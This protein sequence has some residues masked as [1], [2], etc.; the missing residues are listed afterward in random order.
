MA[1]KGAPDIDIFS[2]LSI[3]SKGN[4]LSIKGKLTGDNYPS[5]EAFIS[6]PSGQSVFLGIGVKEGNPYTSLKGKNSRPITSFSLSIITDADGNFTGVNAKGKEYSIADWNK[7]Y[8]DK[9]PRKMQVPLPV[10]K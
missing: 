8:K 1:P 4:M 6:D 7:I 10:M 9:N 3:T 2:A 5:T